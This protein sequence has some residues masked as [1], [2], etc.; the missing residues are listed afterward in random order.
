MKRRNQT[1]LRRRRDVDRS[2]DKDSDENINNETLVDWSNKNMS[3]NVSND[4]F[5]FDDSYHNNSNDND[6][7][8]GVD[9][10]V[11]AAPPPPR[12]SSRLASKPRPV[13]CLSNRGKC[14]SDPP[15]H[16][17]LPTEREGSM[18][19]SEQG[20][21]LIC[22]TGE[23]ERKYR[24]SVCG[25][26]FFQIGHL[27]KHQFIHTDHKP[28]RCDQCGRSYTSAESFRAHQPAHVRDKNQ[29]SDNQKPSESL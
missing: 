1:S 6:I 22:A 24:C 17:E 19:A 26:K 4:K 9:S 7:T 20:A 10:C 3:H 15:T 12:C 25:K 16:K 14:H 29:P 23:R 28:Y 2:A 21:G 27:K 18:R 5:N 11:T 13:H 8:D